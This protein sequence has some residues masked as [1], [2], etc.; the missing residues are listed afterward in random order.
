MTRSVRGSRLPGGSVVMGSTRGA[1]PRVKTIM[2]KNSTPKPRVN[3]ARGDG[4]FWQARWNVASRY[5]Q[6][7]KPKTA[8]GASHARPAP[9]G[10]R[11]PGGEG[12]DVE[13][14]LLH[15]RERDP[16]GDQPRADAGDKLGDSRLG[17]ARDKEEARADDGERRGR[18]P[19]FGSEDEHPGE[20]EGLERDG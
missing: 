14:S 3:E 19:L 15:Q 10:G 16:R 2:A 20:E 5:G 11:A 9:G 7:M 18:E 4:E 13:R 6:S 17:E 12:V 8:T 1:Y